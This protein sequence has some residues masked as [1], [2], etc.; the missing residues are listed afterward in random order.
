MVSVLLLCRIAICVPA[1]FGNLSG[2]LLIVILFAG[3][4]VSSSLF[5]AAPGLLLRRGYANLDYCA[6]EHVER[7]CV[8]MFAGTP[9]RF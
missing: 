2:V 1:G 9:G 6:V 3:F 8:R 7:E 4:P 5:P